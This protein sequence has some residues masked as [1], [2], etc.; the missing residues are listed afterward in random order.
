MWRLTLLLFLLLSFCGI[1][2][3]SSYRANKIA[4]EVSTLENTQKNNIENELNNLKTQL[5][6][7]ALCCKKSQDEMVDSIKNSNT[8]KDLHTKGPKTF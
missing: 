1:I 2:E 4:A 7:I 5:Q 3:L 6:E 8:L